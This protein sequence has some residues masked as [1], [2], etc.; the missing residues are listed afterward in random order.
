MNIQRVNHNSGSISTFKIS[1]LVI[2]IFI[3]GLISGISLLGLTPTDND[4]LDNNNLDLKEDLKNF[5]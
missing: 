3:G 5:G 4:N 1:G 2:V